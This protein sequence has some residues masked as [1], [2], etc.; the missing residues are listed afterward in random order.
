MLIDV[1]DNRSGIGL[2]RMI[3][4]L[5][6]KLENFAAATD[7]AYVFDYNGFCSYIGHN[8]AIDSKM[9]YLTK[10]PL[11]YPATKLLAREYMRWPWKTSTVLVWF[12]CLR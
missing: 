5:N 3:S 8:K 10:S 4:M 7:Y 6:L 11:S 12:R 1:L 2:K 9:Y